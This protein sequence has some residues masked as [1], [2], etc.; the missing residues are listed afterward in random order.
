MFLLPTLEVNVGV[1]PII[2][3]VTTK[4]TLTCTNCRKTSH[5]V[6]TCHNRKKDV[7]IVPIATIKSKKH[8]VRTKT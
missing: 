8:V 7:P 1:K 5:L 4:L 2:H 3:V 6:E